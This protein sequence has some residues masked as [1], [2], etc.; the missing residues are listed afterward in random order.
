MG[1]LT[2]IRICFYIRSRG[3]FLRERSPGNGSFRWMFPRYSKEW[4]AVIRDER[5]TVYRRRPFFN[6][7]VSNTVDGPRGPAEV[8]AAGWES[9]VGRRRILNRSPF[10]ANLRPFFENS[11]PRRV[12]LSRILRRGNLY[13]NVYIYFDSQVFVKKLCERKNSKVILYEEFIIS[14]F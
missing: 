11:L 14:S 9:L 10:S 7:N 4:A 8:E 2:R 13:R 1:H 3:E 5:N 12:N 6:A